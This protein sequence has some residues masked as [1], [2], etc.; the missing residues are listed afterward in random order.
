MT[1]KND[2]LPID[3]NDLV[4]KQNSIINIKIDE[5]NKTKT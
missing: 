1:L 2:F 4:K 3:E 5:M